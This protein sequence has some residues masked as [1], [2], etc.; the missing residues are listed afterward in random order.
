MIPLITTQF[1]IK[2]KISTAFFYKYNIHIHRK[3]HLAANYSYIFV[4]LYLA[5]LINIWTNTKLFAYLSSL[6]SFMSEGR[7]LE[8]EYYCVPQHRISHKAVWSMTIRTV[9]ILFQYISK[10]N[11]LSLYSLSYHLFDVW[12]PWRHYT[13]Y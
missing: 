3:N 10:L 5:V 1:K 9:T 6:H 4:Y 13:S 2:M 11:F 8:F 7:L 12:F